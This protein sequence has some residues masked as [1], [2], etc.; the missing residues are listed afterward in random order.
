M[1][2]SSSFMVR[3]LL[4]FSAVNLWSGTRC[5]RRLNFHET[6]QVPAADFAIGAAVRFAARLS[7]T[8][9]IDFP[10][11]GLLADADFAPA[12]PSFSKCVYARLARRH[13][14]EAQD[15]SLFRC[16]RIDPT[17]RADAGGT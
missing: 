14:K 7:S 1:G 15:C 8:C 12:F 4:L 9:T 5:A 10:R 11:T 2:D 16:V 3:I 17:L 13:P 6:R